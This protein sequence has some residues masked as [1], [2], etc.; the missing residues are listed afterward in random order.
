[1]FREICL[2]LNWDFTE[3]HDTC[4][5]HNNIILKEN[6]VQ[7]NFGQIYKVK[8]YGINYVSHLKMQN[9]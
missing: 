7:T 1:M 4:L 2:N 9:V 8:E 6:H 5:L 3:L